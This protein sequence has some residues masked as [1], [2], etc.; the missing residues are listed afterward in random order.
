MWCGSVYLRKTT[1]AARAAMPSP[2]TAGDALP[3]TWIKTPAAAIAALLKP[4][5][6]GDA[7]PFTW[8]KRPQQPQDQ[9]YPTIQAYDGDVLMFT[10]ERLQ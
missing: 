5:T 8:I 7:L 6:T 2:T 3:F 4:T 10:W 9:Q 1:A